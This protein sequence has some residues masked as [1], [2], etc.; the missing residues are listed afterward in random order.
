VWY[1]VS[2]AVNIGE[3][4]FQLPWTEDLSCRVLRD[5][6]GNYS[7]PH[8]FSTITRGVSRFYRQGD[9]RF[10]DQLLRTLIH[11]D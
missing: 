5:A 2:T 6:K 10:P 4:L 7:V 3:T 1:W 8:L 11:A 9:S